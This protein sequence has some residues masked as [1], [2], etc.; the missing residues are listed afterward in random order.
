MSAYPLPSR[1]SRDCMKAK[2]DAHL[3]ILE[4]PVLG[5]LAASGIAPTR[6]MQ[7]VKE[8]RQPLR[9]GRKDD[10]KRNPTLQGLS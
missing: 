1:E 5:R 8:P 3:L 6:L 9:T 7:N 2:G 10:L 4:K